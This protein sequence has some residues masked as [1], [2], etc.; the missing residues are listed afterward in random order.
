MNESINLSKLKYLESLSD[1]LACASVDDDI[2]CIE[3]RIC[4]IINAEPT[5]TAKLLYMKAVHLRLFFPKLSNDDYEKKYNKLIDLSALKGCKEAQYLKAC[6]LYEDKLYIKAISLYKLSMKQGYAPS[7]WCYG[8]DKFF[9]ID[10]I[11][12]KNKAE[13]LECMR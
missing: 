2:S 13:G 12:S 1:A 5:P 7:L 11:I 8:L 4:K 10:D 6:R 3:E 9:G